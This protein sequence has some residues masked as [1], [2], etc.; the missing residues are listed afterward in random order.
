[1]SGSYW[2]HE[3]M[4][5]N[6]RVS[7]LL[8]SGECC[9]CT[10]LVGSEPNRSRLKAHK[11]ILAAASPV[12]MAMFY[13]SMAEKG[14]IEILDLQPEDFET[15]LQ[16]IYT[17]NASFC[18]VEKTFSVYYGAKKYMLQSLEKEC[19]LFISL[20]INPQNICRVYKFAR[21]ND[22]IQLLDQCVQILTTKTKEVV[23]NWSLEQDD[24]G[25]LLTLLSYESLN[26]GS[27]LD[28]FQAVEKYF[29]TYTPRK[30]ILDSY[31]SLIRKTKKCPHGGDSPAH[32]FNVKQAVN[33]AGP[34]KSEINN[35]EVTQSSS[36]KANQRE[37]SV[38]CT[39]DVEKYNC[40]SND[41]EA[42]LSCIFDPNSSN[43]MR[44]FETIYTYS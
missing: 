13:G 12:F 27:E 42:N 33:E 22:E 20:N 43:G 19:L 2:Q 8:Q 38:E 18:S 39:E 29:N 26:I 4:E 9:D 7:H 36:K 10:F 11:V 14:P 16:Y 28:L 23:H 37:S 15:I 40:K 41:G 30:R 1:M 3:F 6:Q 32:K 31:D 17:K 25:I 21:F 35:R 24:I 34:S 5:W 44:Y